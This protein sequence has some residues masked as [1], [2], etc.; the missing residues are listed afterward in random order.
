MPTPFDPQTG[1]VNRRALAANVA[2][3]MATGLTGALAL[4]SNGEAALLDE[5][6]ADVVVAT[7]RGAMPAGRPLLVGTGR[8]STRATIAATTRAPRRTAPTRCSCARRR[9]SRDR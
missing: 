2:R 1:E 3:W 6:E 7:T 8:E 5:D 9:F 4:G